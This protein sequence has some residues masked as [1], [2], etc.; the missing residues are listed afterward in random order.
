MLHDLEMPGDGQQPRRYGGSEHVASDEAL[1]L[2][3]QLGDDLRSLDLPGMHPSPPPPPEPA[4]FS[5]WRR[6]AAARLEG[7]L[8]ELDARLVVGEDATRAARR[9][10]E[11]VMLWTRR[12][13]IPFSTEVGAA[14]MG[15]YLRR[16][17]TA[18]WDE[19]AE[20]VIAAAAEDPGGVESFLS[21]FVEL[22]AEA[23]ES[24]FA[25]LLA[26]GGGR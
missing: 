2:M 16:G 23:A 10:V 19:L 3:V 21:L 14:R 11:G 25:S 26:P 15:A 13:L 8:A 6:E 17:E 7:A 1:D 5:D 20:Q 12:S 4:A 18:L 24:G 9:A 22:A